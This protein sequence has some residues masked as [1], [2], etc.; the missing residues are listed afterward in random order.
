[1]NGTTINTDKASSLTF[2]GRV[3]ISRAS[4]FFNILL[5]GLSYVNGDDNFVRDFTVFSDETNR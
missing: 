2:K 5:F 4:D 3:K 1:M